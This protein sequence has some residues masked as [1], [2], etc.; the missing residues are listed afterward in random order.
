[1]PQLT[2]LSNPDVTFHEAN[3]IVRNLSS[4]YNGENANQAR[5][6]GAYR[7]ISIYAD[8][9]YGNKNDE[10]VEQAIRD[11]LGDMRHLCD[12]FDIDFDE[13]LERSERTYRDE[14]VNPIG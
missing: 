4:E 12:R 11:L 7:V 5:S 1:M 8:H 9:A 10:P 14:L 13:L 3:P 2:F 6:G